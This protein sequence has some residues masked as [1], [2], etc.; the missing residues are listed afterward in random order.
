MLSG[1]DKIVQLD[2]TLKDLQRE[3]AELEKSIKLLE[4]ENSDQGKALDKLSSGV[5]YH[6]K[7]KNLV[8]ELRVWKDKVK[9][10]EK[11]SQKDKETRKQQVEMIKKI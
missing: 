6:T 1:V 3:K 7:I 8:E 4:R 2:S 11:R 9:K 5:E 10:L